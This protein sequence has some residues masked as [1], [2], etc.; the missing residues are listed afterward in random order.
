[1]AKRKKARRTKK[2]KT[3]KRKKARKSVKRKRKSGGKNAWSAA[4]LARY[5]RAKKKFIKAFNATSGA[6]KVRVTFGAE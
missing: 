1:M 5:K 6:K 4:K 3:V 2:R